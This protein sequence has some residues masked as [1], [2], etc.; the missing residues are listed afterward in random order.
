MIDYA[1]L[2]IVAVL[3]WEVLYQVLVIMDIDRISDNDILEN[4][5][6]RQ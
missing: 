2:A 5:R 6:E 4:R 1:V 3:I